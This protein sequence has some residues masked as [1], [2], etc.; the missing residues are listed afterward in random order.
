M[1]GIPDSQYNTVRRAAG[2]GT[3]SARSLGRAACTTSSLSAGSVRSHS[4][5]SSSAPS[6]AVGWPGP[7][8]VDGME[9]ALAASSLAC[10]SCSVK[11]RPVATGSG[12]KEASCASSALDIL[13]IC[14]WRR[15]RPLHL[16][17]AEDAQDAAEASLRRG[18]SS[19]RNIQL[20]KELTEG[21]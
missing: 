10:R 5:S 11:V 4:Q 18:G 16:H 12:G 19:Q 1:T 7:S 3:C 6:L 9:R 21:Q 14:T 20:L 17:L 2:R 8:T 13:F 15:T